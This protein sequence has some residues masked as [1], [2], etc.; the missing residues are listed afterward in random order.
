MTGGYVHSAATYGR[1]RCGTYGG[2]QAHRKRGEPACQA[3]AVAHNARQ[4][5]YT[6]ANG[7][8]ARSGP[9]EALPPETVHA[10]RLTVCAYA[11]DADDAREL[12]YALGLLAEEVPS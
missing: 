5:E 11:T 10:A 3:C 6:L 9:L 8:R 1:R 7:R 2:Y 12:L 4:I